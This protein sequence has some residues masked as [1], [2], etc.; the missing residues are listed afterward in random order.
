ML[1]SQSKSIHMSLL[2]R[3]SVIYALCLSSSSP[4][5]SWVCLPCR[6][7]NFLVLKLILGEAL[8]SSFGSS[9]NCSLSWA[10]HPSGQQN[11]V[12]KYSVVSLSSGRHQKALC[13]LP[14]PLGQ[15][16]V[17]TPWMM[18]ILPSHH[19]TQQLYRTSSKSKTS[20]TNRS[21]AHLYFA[22]GNKSGLG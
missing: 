3:E 6:W 1:T 13:F 22:S 20:S 9:S 21:L 14:L 11:S 17:R 5:L 8:E 12:S 10:G 19:S 16:V 18:E 2:N 7:Q 15:D 4:N